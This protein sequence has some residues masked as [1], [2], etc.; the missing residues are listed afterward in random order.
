VRPS[1]MPN[2][3]AHATGNSNVVKADV[4]FNYLRAEVL[5]PLLSAPHGGES[6]PRTR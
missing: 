2:A 3:T 1:Q 6:S 5:P 4:L